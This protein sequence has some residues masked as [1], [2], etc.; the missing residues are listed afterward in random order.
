MTVTNFTQTSDKPY[1]RHHYKLVLGNGQ[2]VIVP[3][4]DDIW[5]L[6]GGASTSFSH[7]E[8]LDKPKPK[9]EK[10]RGGKGF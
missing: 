6:W 9:K 7:V 5:R 10:K 4:W 1:D 8:V 2:S 3:S